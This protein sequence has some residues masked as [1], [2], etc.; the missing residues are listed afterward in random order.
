[1]HRQQ[2]TLDAQRFS[3]RRFRRVVTGHDSFGRSV[4]LSDD[5]SPHAMPFMGIEGLVVTD[6]WKSD[7]TPVDNGPATASDPCKVPISIAPPSRGA[8]FRMTQFPPE[9]TWRPGSDA[10]PSE[11]QPPSSLKGSNHPHMHETTTLDYAVVVEGEIWM[12]MEDGETCMRAGD[13][14]IQRGTRHA[15]ANRSDAPCVIAFVMIDA[16]PR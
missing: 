8:V 7:S 15:W 2:D 9:S 5:R 3:T 13:V 16:L 10:T 1:M 14:V 4:I 12:V 6:L 11:D